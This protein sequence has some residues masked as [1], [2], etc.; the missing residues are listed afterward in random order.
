M[1]NLSKISN[2]LQFKSIRVKLVLW[3]LPVSILPMVVMMLAGL[4]YSDNALKKG[5]TNRLIDNRYGIEMELQEQEDQLIQEVRRNAELPV[6]LKALKSKDPKSMGELI[7][8]ILALSQSELM[9][10]YDNEG[11][12]YTL[13]RKKKNIQ[14][15]M[16]FNPKRPLNKVR[17]GLPSFEWFASAY[18]QEE[19]DFLFEESVPSATES[20][21]NQEDDFGSIPEIA[22]RIPESIVKRIQEQGSYVHRTSEDNAIRISVYKTVSF[23]GQQIGILHQAV[24]LGEIFVVHLKEKTGLD[25]VLLGKKGKIIVSTRTEQDVPSGVEERLLQADG[26][27]I[28]EIGNS[29]YTLLPLSNAGNTRE[30]GIGLFQSL[31]LYR[32]E[33]R[34][35]TVFFV[36]LFIASTLI[37]ALVTYFV[38]GSF[39]RPI[40]RVT[41]EVLK[42]AERE[43]DLTLKLPVQSR[44]EVGQLASSFNVMIKSFRDLIF[45][46]RDAGLQMT[47]QASQISAGV[48]Q[49]ATG[50][51][52]QSSAVTT[53]TNTVEALSETATSIAENALNLARSSEETLT[54]MEDTKAKVDAVAQK[55]MALG[56]KSEAVGNITNLIE[57]LADRTNLLALNASIEA[58]R[59]GEA[60]HGFSVVAV[61]VGKLAEQSSQSTNDI[62]AIIS[63]IQSEIHSTIMEVEETTKR[64]DQ[65]LQMLSEAVQVIKEISISTQQQRSGAEQVVQAIME[66]EDVTTTFA[67]TT[68]QTAN[69]ADGLSQLAENLKNAISGF[70][71]DE[72]SSSSK[73]D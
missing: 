58:A 21:E 36:I 10:L 60:G 7:G 53:V 24:E 3:F 63:E 39:S 48:G 20:N 9:G 32:V 4:S 22:S 11:M 34:E 69:H 62:R 18:A 50:A 51:A 70:K 35:F 72:D 44:D 23:S 30:G 59:A 6:L 16:I 49:Q 19:D 42:V 12:P 67:S 71:L 41:D 26:Q 2:G 25:I 1:V 61:E 43:G 38:A 56:E 8:Q 28:S 45:G 29:F 68:Q 40:L 52:Q 14:G 13:R 33:K 31:D 57:D 27:I 55:V 37:V 5:I 65:G 64:T 15:S 46:I 66:I 73:Q 47:A 17:Q 54:G